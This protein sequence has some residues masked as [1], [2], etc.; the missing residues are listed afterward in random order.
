[1]NQSRNNFTMEPHHQQKE[2]N[3]VIRTP[4]FT[5]PLT[6]SSPPKLQEKYHLC[7][8]NPQDNPGLLMRFV[9]I[10][11]NDDECENDDVM[12]E[13]NIRDSL[14]SNLG[15][16][17]ENRC[18]KDK[19]ISSL[20]TFTNGKQ[21]SMFLPDAPIY[22]TDDSFLFQRLSIPDGFPSSRYLSESDR[23]RESDCCNHSRNGNN[24]NYN[25]NISAHSY[26]IPKINLKPRQSPSPENNTISCNFRPIARYPSQGR[27]D[28]PR[29]FHQN[30]EESQ[31]NVSPSTQ[32]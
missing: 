20:P 17:D 31:E 4:L 7:R 1:M 13:I 25:N 11:S 32:F 9:P 23:I 22:T 16:E 26:R 15:S 10:S 18:D 24:Y 2:E 28:L 29:D 21:S 5:Y 8:E 14:T 12:N 30:V 27:L 19:T 3:D 6:L